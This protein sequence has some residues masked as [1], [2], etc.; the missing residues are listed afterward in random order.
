MATDDFARPEGWKITSWEI[1]SKGEG[2]PEDAFVVGGSLLIAIGKEVIPPV[3]DL[4]WLDGSGRW[5]TV[6][7]LDL[8]VKADTLAASG[9]AAK[10]GP[11]AVKCQ[12][13]LLLTPASAGG[14]LATIRGEIQTDPLSTAN[15]GSFAAEAHIP[16]FEKG[17][18][19]LRDLCR[20]LRA[21]RAA[22]SRAASSRRG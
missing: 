22:R 12:V 10:I 6:A 21:R 11:A 16:P 9:V 3:Y 2:I 5:C 14:G 20:F 7:G 1:T 4:A 13:Q 8:S 15:A 19:L 17:S 18:S